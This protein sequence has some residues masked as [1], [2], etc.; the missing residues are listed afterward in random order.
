MILTA[1]AALLLLWFGIAYGGLPRLW[2]HHE[3][4]KI[5]TRDEI[6]SYTAQDIPADPINLRVRGS[7]DQIGCAMTKGGWTRADNVSVRSAAKIAASVVLDHAYPGAPVSSLYLHDKV[8]DMAFELD[9]G[10]SADKRHHVRFWQVAPNDWLAAATFDRGVG[11]SLFTL[12]ITHYIGSDPDRDRILVGDVLQAA[13]AERRG[14][15]TSRIPPGQCIATVAA[16]V[17]GPTAS[18]GPTGSAVL[19]R[20]RRTLAWGYRRANQSL[21][22]SPVRDWRTAKSRPHSIRRKTRPNR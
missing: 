22:R 16:I 12:Q 10:R 17:I 1:I 3:H 18:S 14:T 9:E 19:V 8:Q 7:A 6:V 21:V 11:L 2:S 15:A 4:K 13:G 20:R 5:G